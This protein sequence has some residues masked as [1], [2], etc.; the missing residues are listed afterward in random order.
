MPTRETF[1]FCCQCCDKFWIKETCKYC[2][3]LIHNLCDKCS[4]KCCTECD[5]DLILAYQHLQGYISDEEFKKR[6]RK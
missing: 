1:A 6:V 4:D 5:T 3:D 2:N